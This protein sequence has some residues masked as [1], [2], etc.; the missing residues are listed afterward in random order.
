[1]ASSVVR[2]E[3][4]DRPSYY[5][6]RCVTEVV[7]LPGKEGT[8]LAELMALKIGP[9]LL[10]TMPGEPMVEY[11][12]NI[13]KIIADRAIPIVVGYANGSIGYIATADSH[14]V[15]GYEPIVSYL[16]PEAESV[17]YEAL[18]RLA[19][20]VIGDVFQSFSKHDTDITRGQK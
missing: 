1:L 13:E 6:I 18:D 8:V 4:K 14:A 5:P 3:L 9:Y 11:G 15:G 17:I 2:E 20:Q 16:A 10:L 19:D 7:E 12:L